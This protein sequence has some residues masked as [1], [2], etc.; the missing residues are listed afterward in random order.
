MEIETAKEKIIEALN[1]H[2]L[3]FEELKPVAEDMLTLRQCVNMLLD[4]MRIVSNKNGKLATPEQCGLRRGKLQ[5][6]HAGYGFVL[7]PD[8]DI[9]IEKSNLHG[10]LNGEIVLV[11]IT[12][13]FSPSGPEGKVIKVESKPYIAVGTIKKSRQG[14]ILVPDDETIGKIKIPRKY[15]GSAMPNDKAVVEITRRASRTTMHEGKI[16]ELLG[17][18][19]DQGVDILSIARTFG[20]KDEFPKDV[21]SFVSGLPKEVPE[22]A[23]K[24]RE[25]LFHKLIFTI[26][27]DDA[28]DLDDA[29]SLE[30]LGDGSYILGVHIA[31]VSN[32]VKEDSAIDKEALRRATSVYMVDRVIPMLPRELSNGLCSLNEGVVRLT[33]S[34]FIKLDHMGNVISH[35]ICKSA[36]KSAYRMTYNDVNKILAGEKDVCERYSDIVATVKSMNMLAHQLRETRFL[37]GGLDFDIPEAKIALDSDGFPCDISLRSRGDAEKLIEEFMLLCN[38]T[39]AAEYEEKGLPFVYRIHEKPDKDRMC[40]LSEFLATFGYKVPKDGFIP[41]RV[42]NKILSET[43]HSPDEAIINRVILR[44]LK[45]ARYSTVN[46]GHFGLAS[47]AYCH[48]TSPIRRY[49]DLQIH[50]IIKEDIEGKLDENRI[51][52]LNRRL[53]NTANISSERERNAIDAERKVDAVKMAEYMQRHLGD[54]YPA[55]ISGVTTNCLFAELENTIEGVIPLSTLKNDYYELD[56]ER[57][58]VKGKRS[59]KMIRLGDSIKICVAAASKEDARIEFSLISYANK[60]KKPVAK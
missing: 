7:Q 59:G 57:Y 33:L 47:E 27:G 2:S 39:V 6:K 24:D 32:Y 36:I 8:G 60:R 19:D 29:V 37:K 55:V 56:S 43:E 13:S 22:S 50:R 28:K 23:L 5:I 4:E 1:D 3:S 52:K 16:I 45:K 26:D 51:L 25:L 14:T 12:K 44:S 49:P 15:R 48:F 30:T 54:E 18:A 9:Y 11:K 41:S 46:E 21:L 10:A 58:L 35:K 40:E 38:N 31:D 42:L 20:L 34:C 17:N 53:P